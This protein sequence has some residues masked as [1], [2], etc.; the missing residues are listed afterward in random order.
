MDITIRSTT[1][2]T[3]LSS[4]DIIL[5]M[6]DMDSDTGVMDMEVMAMGAMDMEAMAAII[7]ASITHPIAVTGHAGQQQAGAATWR[8]MHAGTFVRRLRHVVL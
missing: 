6:L 7:L 8:I 4:M 5:D 1:D 3:T 2:S